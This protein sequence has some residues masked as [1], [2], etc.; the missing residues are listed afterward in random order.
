MGA[1][2]C[3]ELPC[4]RSGVVP[5]RCTL[6]SAFAK[7]AIKYKNA[8]EFLEKVSGLYQIEQ[9][10]STIKHEKCPCVSRQTGRKIQK[11][12]SA[13]KFYALS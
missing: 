10:L 5:Q 7:I 9:N 6:S 3:P 2:F 1:K 11:S 4:L 12:M 13:F 8:M